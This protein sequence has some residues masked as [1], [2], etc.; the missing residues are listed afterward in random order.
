MTLVRRNNL[1]EL[2]DPF[3]F[4]RNLLTWDPFARSEERPGGFAARFEVKETEDA[5]QLIGDFPG[6]KEEDLDISLDGDVITVSGARRAEDKKEGETY[7]VY[8]RQYGS[9][10]RSFRLPDHADRDQVNANLD[11]GVL[12]VTIP[13]KEASKPRKIALT[14]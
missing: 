4:A 11:A 9:F 3:A 5:F 6:L 13:K 1:D 7:Y 10:S 12:T 8:E 2:R 14:K